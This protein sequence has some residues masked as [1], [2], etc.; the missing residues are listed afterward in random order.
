MTKEIEF[1]EHG[2][3]AF[4]KEGVAAGWL[5][6]EPVIIRRLNDSE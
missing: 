6:G 3:K 5:D 2:E 4:E 1:G